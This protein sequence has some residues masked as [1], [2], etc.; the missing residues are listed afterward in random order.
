MTDRGPGG[1]DAPAGRVGGSVVDVA[2]VAARLRADC[3]RCAGLCCV[4]PGFTRSADFPVSKPPGVACGHLT[5]GFTCGVHD[6]LRPRGFHGCVVFDCHGAGQQ[7]T[8][9][10]FAGGDWRADPATATRMFDV[11]AVMRTLH[12]SLRHLAEALT[13][14]DAAVDASPVADGKLLAALRAEWAAALAFTEADADTLLA[15]DLSAH[16]RAV[17]T[18]LSR[19]SA[20]LRAHPP[21]LPAAGGDGGRGAAGGRG[22]GPGSGRG[23]PRAR[24]GG[25]AGRPAPAGVLAADLVGA[26]LAGADL[27]GADLAGRLLLGADLRRADLRAADL[28][29]ADLRG[30]ELGGA[31]LR[32]ALFVTQPQLDSAR[33]DTATILP[34]ALVRPAHWPA[35]V[36][37]STGRRR[38]RRR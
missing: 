15:V 19:A 5:G 8:E 7:V 20:R 10:T 11:F 34:A 37:P 36:P 14:L 25:P 22:P 38:A 6:E 3:G 28:R 9:V 32:G 29:G 2:A 12:E 18:V 30:A 4:A 31:D 13:L 33:G 27:R 17:H 21:G 24:G 23:G 35:Q 1:G 26:R 16:R